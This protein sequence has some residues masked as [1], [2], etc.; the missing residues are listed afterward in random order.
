MLLLLLSELPKLLYPNIFLF[1]FVDELIN[2]LFCP[3][4]YPKFKSI[5]KCKFE[6]TC[7]DSNFV[8]CHLIKC[9]GELHHDGI[10]K[11]GNDSI[12]DSNIDESE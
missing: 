9:D 12:I 3:N 7:F 8:R 1:V 2:V 10:C 11:F 4:L 5:H 6:L